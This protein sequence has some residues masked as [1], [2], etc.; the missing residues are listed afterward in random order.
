MTALG[1]VLLMLIWMALT[2]SAHPSFVAAGA[3]C[4]LSVALLWR[5]ILPG[6]LSSA[7]VLVRHPIR[8]AR[9]AV[10]LAYRFAM[11]TLHTAWLILRGGEEG[12][13]VALPLHV[14]DPLAQFILL[15]AI[16]LTPS[17]ISLLTEDNLLY[18]HWLQPAGGQGDWRSIK[19]SLE[20]CLRSLFEDDREGR[21]GRG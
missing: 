3:V 11:S 9:F 12:R 16:T 6:S 1:F 4:S 8:T 20:R 15:N 10:T 18:I 2:R 21:S 19:E 14:T 5:A 7:V 17:T 13:M